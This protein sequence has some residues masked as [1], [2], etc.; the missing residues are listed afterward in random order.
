[1]NSLLKKLKFIKKIKVGLLK[2]KKKFP[3]F[4]PYRERERHRETDRDRGRQKK[5]LWKLNHHKLKRKIILTESGP[6]DELFKTVKVIDKD[7]AAVTVVVYVEFMQGYA[8]CIFDIE[9][10]GFVTDDNTV[11]NPVFPK[12][13]RICLKF[14]YFFFP[15]DC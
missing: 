1:M 13:L 14:R 15:R 3:S 12:Q 6:I 7:V 10:I 4:L 11:A 9:S 8:N 2:K 5:H